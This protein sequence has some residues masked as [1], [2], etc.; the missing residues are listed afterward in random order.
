LY[1]RLPRGKTY[2]NTGRAYNIEIKG[3]IATARVR[4]SRPTAYKVEIILSK[5]SVVEQKF[6]HQTTITPNHL[7]ALQL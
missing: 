6:I 3:N 7:S 1:N 4:G 5:F 2:A